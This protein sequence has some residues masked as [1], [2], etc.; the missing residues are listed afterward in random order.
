MN[1]IHVLLTHT[2]SL[3]FTESKELRLVHTHQKI[4]GRSDNI[5]LP[6]FRM[7]RQLINRS[8]AIVKHKYLLSAQLFR[9]GMRG[10]RKPCAFFIGK[11]MHQVISRLVCIINPNDYGVFIGEEYFFD[12]KMFPEYVRREFDLVGSCFCC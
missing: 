6:T 4:L 11:D 9:S 10:K 2:V 8:L 5:Y 12:G 7:I 1:F 3:T